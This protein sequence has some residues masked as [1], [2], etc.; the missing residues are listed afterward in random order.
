MKNKIDPYQ[1]QNTFFWCR[2]SFFT[3]WYSF[4]KI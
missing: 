1:T 4:R 3:I 2:I